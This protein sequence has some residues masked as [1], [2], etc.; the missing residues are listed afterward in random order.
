MKSLT[1][2]RAKNVGCWSL[3]LECRYF[4]VFLPPLCW[5]MAKILN[6]RC[7]QSVQAAMDGAREDNNFWHI[8]DAAWAKIQ[9]QSVDYAILE[10]TDQIV[11]VKFSGAWSDLGDWNAVAGQL[12]HDGEGNFITGT[13]SQIDCNNTTLWSAA[14]GYTACGAWARKYCDR[15]DG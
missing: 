7:W 3:C 14:N 2:H 10:K 11:C 12:P 4:F 13:A 6:P 15:G 8:D 9:G 5:H 1:G